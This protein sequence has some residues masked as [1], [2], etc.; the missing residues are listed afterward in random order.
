MLTII[1][2]KRKSIKSI[3]TKLYSRLIIANIMNVTMAIICAFTI[4]HKDELPILNNFIGKSLILLFI[5]WE[6]IFTIYIIAITRKTNN[7]TEIFIK[8]YKGI[9]IIAYVLLAITIY[10]LPLYYH[11]ESNIVYSYGPSANLVYVLTTILIVSWIVI[12]LKNSTILKSKK[13]I[14]VVL[15][16]IM[17]IIVV[18]IQKLNPG[19]LLITA[20]E[21]FIT[22]LMY[23]TIENPDMKL[24]EESYKAKEISDNANE[25]KTLFLYNMTQEIR[26]I[27]NTINNDA[28]IILDRK[29]MKKYM[30]V[31][32]IL[33][34]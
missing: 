1:Y 14:P 10:S 24:L 19:L 4:I 28:D 32:E 25:E 26:G 6:L 21:T 3:E 27:T 2:F 15:F 11:N 17:T 31:L 12:I 18:I 16:I 33:K 7:S 9:L 20:T 5:T 13:S 29:I 34:H 30:I 8:K 22:V 23:F